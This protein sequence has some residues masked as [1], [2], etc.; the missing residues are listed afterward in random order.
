[1]MMKMPVVLLSCWH[2]DLSKPFGCLF[3]Y[4]SL[5]VAHSCTRYLIIFKF[6]LLFKQMKMSG[7]RVHAPA[8][9]MACEMW[10]SE[11]SQKKRQIDILSA[12][13]DL[14]GCLFA[15]VVFFRVCSFATAYAVW[16]NI[17]TVDMYADE[18]MLRA[19]LLMTWHDLEQK[20]KLNRT[21][22]QRFIFFAAVCCGK[23]KAFG[24]NE[25]QR[26]TYTCITYTK[27]HILYIQKR[28]K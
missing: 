10:A 13:W 19:P 16:C 22:N 2:C 20:K 26:L 24:E 1:M 9:R 23:Q 12:F 14:L 25:R 5:S 8:N 27:M 15:V 3:F 17:I 4:L 11:R 28:K 18:N 7:A 21:E 6:T